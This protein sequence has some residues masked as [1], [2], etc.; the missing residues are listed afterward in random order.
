MVHLQ[1]LIP[2]TCIMSRIEKF[3]DEALQTRNSD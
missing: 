2:V 3:L 1:Q